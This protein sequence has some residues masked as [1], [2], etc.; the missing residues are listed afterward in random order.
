M[1]EV[2]SL[3]EL[4]NLFKDN[5]EGLC[6]AEHF[7]DL[8]ETR[9]KSYAQLGGGTT[10][11]GTGLMLLDFSASNDFVLTS[12]GITASA[13]NSRMTFNASGTYLLG[14]YMASTAPFTN[15]GYLYFVKNG[16]TGDTNWGRFCD[17]NTNTQATC[18]T[19]YMVREFKAGD[20]VEVWANFASS[21]ALS[22]VVWYSFRLI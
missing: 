18:G 22:G 10:G 11:T 17:G 4:Q 7:R 15:N 21:A 14:I 6:T 16:R 9:F 19:Y 2:R 8:I 13:A 20:Y 3:P 12:A 5:V 1:P